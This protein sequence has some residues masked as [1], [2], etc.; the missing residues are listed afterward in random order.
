MTRSFPKSGKHRFWLLSRYLRAHHPQADHVGRARDHIENGWDIVY[1]Y[2][3][4]GRYP[5]EFSSWPLDFGSWPNTGITRRNYVQRSTRLWR[6]SRKEVMLSLRP[7]ILRVCHIWWL[8][9][10]LVGFICPFH[11]SRTKLIKSLHRNH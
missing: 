9:P 7:T 1:D 3:L 6:K 5:H 10:R 11:Q 4:F 2:V 8:L